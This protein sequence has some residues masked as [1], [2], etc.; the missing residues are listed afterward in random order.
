MRTLRSRLLASLVLVF[1]AGCSTPRL[2]PTPMT[3][4]ELSSYGDG[5]ALATYLTQRDANLSVCDLRSTG[6]HVAAMDEDARKALRQAFEKGA[7]APSVWQKCM[8]SLLASTPADV[9]AGLMNDVLALVPALVDDK[10]IESDNNTQAR[11]AAATHVYTSRKQGVDASHDDALALEDHLRKTMAA[12]KLGP[13]ALGTTKTLL[14]ELEMEHGFVNG[15]LV[16][17]ALLDSLQASGDEATL[18]LGAKRL[19]DAKLRDESKRRVIRMHIA[20]SPYPE[21]KANAG[22]LEELL[23]KGGV[24]RVG[25]RAHAP[26]SASLDASRVPIR[27]VEVQQDVNNQSARLLAYTSDAPSLSVLPVLRLRKALQITLDGV[28][29]PVTLC[30]HPGELDPSPCVGPEDV[31]VDSPLATL[32]RD[33]AFHFVDSI[34]EDTAVQLA[35]PQRHLDMPIVVGGKPLAT[36]GWGLNYATPSD[37][38]FTGDGYGANGPNLSVTADRRDPDRVIYSVQDGPQRFQAVVEWSQAGNFH[39]VSRGAV[40]QPGYDGASGDNG[41]AGQDGNDAVC[42]S[43]PGGDGGR[44]GDGTDGAP[45]GPGGPG[46]S[47]GAV[48]VSVLADANHQGET[49]WMIQHTVSSEGGEGGAGGQGGAGGAGGRGGNGG[50]G[51]TCTA[52]DGS[53]YSL[54]GGNGGPGGCSGAAG[55]NGPDGPDGQPGFVQFDAPSAAVSS[56]E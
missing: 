14:A 6:P 37:L 27:G 19:P 1:F 46:G 23:A 18:R 29:R 54:S 12:G 50:N 9:Q 31:K 26:M 7:I 11:L 39:V 24:N 38:V 41:A 49:T 53:T 42:P 16:D 55:M 28:S 33:G 22:V 35:Q 47:G 43:M 5:A 3:T 13:I 34:T 10:A 17:A 20:A 2:F 44:G 21:V 45:G 56:R 36:L 32:D 15:K 30:G 8:E 25:L 51:A 48:R 4:A 52:N 40:G